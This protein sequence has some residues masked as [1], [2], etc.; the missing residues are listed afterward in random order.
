MGENSKIQKSTELNFQNMKD[1]IHN[2]L[3]HEEENGTHFQKK[4]N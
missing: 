4:S 3:T 1:M 2:Y